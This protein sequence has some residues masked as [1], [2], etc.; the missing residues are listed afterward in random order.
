MSTAYQSSNQMARTKKADPLR[1]SID[2]R[3]HRRDR[4]PRKFL[5]AYIPAEDA[6]AV[7]LASG[8]CHTCPQRGQTA[9]L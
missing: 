6:A 3:Q 1:M 5:P 7:D 4:T 2:A 9:R 8:Q